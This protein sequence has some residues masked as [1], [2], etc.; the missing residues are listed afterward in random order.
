[1]EAG[2]LKEEGELIQN[3]YPHMI[4]YLPDP[5][6]KPFNTDV[7]RYYPNGDKLETN[8]DNLRKNEY[9]S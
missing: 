7:K 2:K 1:M 8:L 9:A 4:V 3:V 5:E 6:G